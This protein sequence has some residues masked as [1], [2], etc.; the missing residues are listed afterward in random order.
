MCKKKKIE[1]RLHQQMA[2]IK[3]IFYQIKV[4]AN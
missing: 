1:T 3:N 4:L 2:N